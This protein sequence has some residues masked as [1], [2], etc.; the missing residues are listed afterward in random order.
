MNTLTLQ[1]SYNI[2][3]KLNRLVINWTKRERYNLGLRL[4]TTCLLLL[5]QI[6]TAEQI[7][8]VM[9]DRYLLEAII[10]TEI[11]KI[12]LRLAME[13]KLL[14]ETNYFYLAEE[15]VE[16]GK[17]LSGWRKSLKRL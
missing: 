13:Q 8:S 17:M 11:L 15:L 1:K 6:I 7:E 16:T 10:K 14:K 2:Y 3:L 12:L 5:E 4:E 9:K